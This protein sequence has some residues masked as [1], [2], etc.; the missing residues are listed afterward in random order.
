[1]G[2]TLFKDKHT[3]VGRYGVGGRV[4]M[5]PTKDIAPNPDQPRRDMSYEKLLELA[6]SI[7][8][9][10]IL[11]P[12]SVAFQDGRPVLVAGE[13]R[14]RAAKI[15]GMKE[16]PCIVVEGDPRERAILSLIE[17]LQRESMNCFETAEGISRLIQVYGLTQEE[18]ASRLGCAQSTIAN[19]LR[20]LRLNQEERQLIIQAGLTERPA[21]ALL[22][23]KE[24][25]RKKALAAIIEKR[26]TVAQTEKMIEQ[27]LNNKTAAKKPKNPP[28]IRDIR[29]FINTVN[30]AIDAIKR[31]GLAASS[32]KH[33]TDDYIEY[34]VRIKKEVA[35]KTG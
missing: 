25:D 8:E 15:L 12:I 22:R 17:N 32:Q 16:V 9:N 3:P 5:I 18:A 28:A 30:H 23:L 26:L 1:M 20:L 14:L 19:R 13:R 31:S 27:M 24:E 34:V 11:N 35:R 2:R 10:G 4:L 6:Q 29:I 33:E 7:S 21:R